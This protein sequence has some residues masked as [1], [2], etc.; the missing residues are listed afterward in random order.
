MRFTFNDFY[1]INDQERKERAMQKVRNQKNRAA[2]IRINELFLVTK[3]AQRFNIQDS[4]CRQ[5]IRDGY[6]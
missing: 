6:K 3:Y 1:K 4:I 2:E 5:I